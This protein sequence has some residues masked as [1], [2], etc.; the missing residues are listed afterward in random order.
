MVAGKRT[1]I[2]RALSS[3]D[4]AGMAPAIWSGMTNTEQALQTLKTLI[5]E[6]PTESVIRLSREVAIEFGL[7]EG[8]RAEMLYA[9]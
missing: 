2:I 5:A 9:L 4:S 6:Q 1:A 8:E 7:T 3:R